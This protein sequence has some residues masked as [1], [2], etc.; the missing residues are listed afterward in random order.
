MWQKYVGSL[1]KGINKPASFQ[2]FVR[3]SIADDATAA[4]TVPSRLVD[5]A[6]AVARSE[7]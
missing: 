1:K 4:R 6:I 5:R 3:N 2:G 7:W